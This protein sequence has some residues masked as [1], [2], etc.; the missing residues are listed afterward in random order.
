ME[1]MDIV[2]VNTNSAKQIYQPLATRWSAIEP[3]TWSL[4]LAQSCR[5]KGYEVAILDA[6]AE[7]LS[8]EETALRVL[9]MKP[10]FCCFVTYGQ[11]PNSGTVSMVGVYEVA[12]LLKEAETEL[13]TISIGSHTQALPR[14]VLRESGG[15]IDYVC[16]NEGVYALH[17]LLANVPAINIP[18]IGFNQIPYSQGQWPKHF[19]NGANSIVPQDRMD[20]DLPG[21]AWDLLPYKEKPFDLYRAHLWHAEYQD[22]YRNPFSAMYTSLGCKFKCNFC[23]INIVNRTSTDSKAVSSDFNNMRFW[24]PELMLKEFDKLIG[25][26]VTTIRLSDEMFF[27]NK[28]YYEPLLLGLKERGYGDILK[29][30][31][32]SRVDTVNERFLDTFREGGIKWLALGIETANQ[33]VRR[34]ITKGKFENVNVRDVVKQISDHGLYTIANYIF[35][36]PTDTL[37]TMQQTLDLALDLNTESANLWTAMALPGS[38]LYYEA[39]ENGWKLPEKF[40]EWSFYSYECQPLPTKHLQPE[41]VLRFRDEAWH[42]YFENPRFLQLVQ[43]KFG[44]DA[45]DNLVEQSKIKLKRRILGD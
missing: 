39:K 13:E 42:K 45:K 29:M 17:Q 27:L 20:I 12:K 3:P 23:M 36:H 1:L 11:Q 25:Y 44:Q 7:N 38:P 2:F 34:E 14:E 33:E 30:W 40:E 15:G 22:K 4:L 9:E 24:S 8:H 41:E 6:I 18:G 10:R 37:E 43:D 21:Y 35:G 31:S 28:K 26:G 19:T 16:I 5:S 32:Y